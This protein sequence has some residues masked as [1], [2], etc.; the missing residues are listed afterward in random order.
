MISIILELT[1]KTLSG[2]PL[3]PGDRHEFKGGEKPLST[4][5]KVLAG[6]AAA[7]GL[8]GIAKLTPKVHKLSKKMGTSMKED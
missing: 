5:G 1:G 6:T 8:Y 4:K 7:G 3:I 2:D